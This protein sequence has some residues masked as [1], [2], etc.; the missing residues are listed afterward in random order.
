MTVALL[1]TTLV[2]LVYFGLALVS[3]PIDFLYRN[4]AGLSTARD[5]AQIVALLAALLVF[6]TGL[7]IAIPTALQPGNLLQKLINVLPIY[8]LGF[9]LAGVVADLLNVGAVGNLFTLPQVGPINFIQAWL[10]LAAI[11]STLGVVIAAGRARLGDRVLQSAVMTTAS[12]VVLSLVAAVAV[13][14]A[15]V[16]LSGAQASFGGFPG[17]GNG[18]GF[19]GGNGGAVSTQEV[20]NNFGGF[21]GAASTQA[22]PNGFPS[23]NGQ[24]APQSGFPGAASTQAAP[25]NFGG[26]GGAASTPDASSGQRQN[27]SFSGQNQVNAPLAPNATQEVGASGQQRRNRQDEGGGSSDGDRQGG[28]QGDFPGGPGGFGGGNIKTNYEVGAGLMAVFAVL[29]LIAVVGAFRVMPRGATGNV[30]PK[31]SVGRE[32]GLAFAS[33][34]VLTIIFGVIIQFVPTTRDNP[35]PVEP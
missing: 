5:I 2:V 33:A 14:A 30:L 10:G 21:G 31:I 35:T 24:G 8:F 15:A 17:G 18:G 29:G 19:P 23:R 27:S 11:L 26:F 3:S 13:I 32:V 28:P 25:N 6:I 34:I 12:A 9:L 7:V 16:I 4:T 22:A 20:S 1:F